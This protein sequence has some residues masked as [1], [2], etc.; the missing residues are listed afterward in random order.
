MTLT[1]IHGLLDFFGII[2]S[3]YTFFA[4]SD[5]NRGRFACWARSIAVAV[6]ERENYAIVN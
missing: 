1:A 4:K 5:R 3:T 6:K 2:A